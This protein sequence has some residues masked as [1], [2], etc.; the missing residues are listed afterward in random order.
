MMIFFKTI[1]ICHALVAALKRL[2][3]QSLTA[4]SSVADV[5]EEPTNHWMETAERHKAI[6]KSI[7][8][9]IV[10]EFIPFQ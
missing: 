1:V 5:Y 7:C 4:V 10:D 9:G 6:L 2:K 3:M 8:E